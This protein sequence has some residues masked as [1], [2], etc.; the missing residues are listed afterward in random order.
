[1]KSPVNG[2]VREFNNYARAHRQA[3][4]LTAQT[5]K[6]KGADRC[7]FI[8]NNNIS[9]IF[10]KANDELQAVTLIATNRKAKE[11]LIV[12]LVI[13][14]L[15]DVFTGTEAK[16]RNSIMN[17]LGLYDKSCLTGKELTVGG[18]KYTITT[19]KATLF[20]T[21]IKEALIE[22]RRIRQTN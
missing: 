21:V 19:A 17:Q 6:F 1:M 11:F 12:P 22:C 8:V 2:F 15:I 13:A 4:R 5:K 14:C 16:E 10:T 3:F 18:Y 20:F 7:T 9:G